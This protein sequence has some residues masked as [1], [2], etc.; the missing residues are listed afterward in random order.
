MNDPGAPREMTRRTCI[1]NC[2]A[3]SERINP[4][5][6]TAISNAFPRLSNRLRN[7]D[8]SPANRPAKTVTDLA[9]ALSATA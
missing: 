8:L 5:P 2:R 7:L 1:R 3:S 6:C 4:S 9:V